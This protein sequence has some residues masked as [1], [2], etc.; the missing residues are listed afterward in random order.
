M[1]RTQQF[2]LTTAIETFSIHSE[3]VSLPQIIFREMNAEHSE[4]V[5]L[6]QTIFREMNAEHAEL[7]SCHKLSLA[8]HQNHQYVSKDSHR[9]GALY[10]RTEEIFSTGTAP[11]PSKASDP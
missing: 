8:F 2:T 10:V 1:Y 11:Q 7:V 9:C 6:P 5:S 4:M 3:L